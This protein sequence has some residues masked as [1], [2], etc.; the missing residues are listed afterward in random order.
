M[1]DE[2]PAGIV[3]Q[4]RAWPCTNTIPLPRGEL[5]GESKIS[6]HSIFF[7]VGNYR[8]AYGPMLREDAKIFGLH[9]RWLHCAFCQ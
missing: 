1:G 5:G 7:P 4:E 2:K 6:Q 3:R 9:K 8:K